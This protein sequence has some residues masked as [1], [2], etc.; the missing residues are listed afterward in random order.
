[1]S[2]CHDAFRGLPL[3]VEQSAERE[4]DGRP[5]WEIRHDPATASIIV[6]YTAELFVHRPHIDHM[7]ST[8][9]EQ[10]HG[11]ARKVRDWEH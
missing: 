2:G 1:M 8:M 6:Q 11:L 7:T 4:P 10:L 3:L 9:Q 5:V